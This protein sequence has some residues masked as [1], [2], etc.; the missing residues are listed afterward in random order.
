MRCIYI[1]TC[2]IPSPESHGEAFPASGCCIEGSA[3][4]GAW[5]FKPDGD[6][7]AY[8][9]DPQRDLVAEVESTLYARQE[10]SE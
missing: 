7:A 8:Y 6:E 9:V 1:G 2:Q 5:L 10:A 4:E 3:E